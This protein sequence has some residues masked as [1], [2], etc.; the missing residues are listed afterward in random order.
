[1]QTRGLNPKITEESHDCYPRDQI[2]NALK[3]AKKAIFFHNLEK[4]MNMT[5]KSMQYSR[6]EPQREK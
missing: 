4:K 6:I 5:K 2:P 1:M 3:R